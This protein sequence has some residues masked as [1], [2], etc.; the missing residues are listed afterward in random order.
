MSES[1][2]SISSY[3]NHKQNNLINRLRFKV[4]KW[5][6]ENEIMIIFKNR[7]LKFLAR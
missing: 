7:K 6:I 1:Q 4:E 2:I 5:D 3:M